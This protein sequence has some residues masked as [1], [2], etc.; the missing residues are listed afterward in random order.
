VGGWTRFAPAPTGYLHLGHVANAIWVWGLA[1]QTNRSVLLRIEDH[2]RERSRPEFDAA[3]LEDLA[4]LGFEPN[5]G[6]VRQRDM[7]G[8]Y[9]SALDRLRGD[10]LVYACHCSR[11]TFATWAAAHGRAFSGPGCP[12]G[13]RERTLADDGQTTLRVALGH[14]EEHWEDRLLGRRS[15]SVYAAGDLPIRDRQDN[16]TYGFAVVADDL[17]QGIDLVVRGEDL[18][19]ATPGQIRLGRLLG[20]RRP[21]Q[22]AHHTL[23]LKPNGAKLSKADNDTG[24]RDLREAGLKAEA[25]IG[26]AA[27]AVG[28]LE[29][30]RD[31]PAKDVATLVSAE[32]MKPERRPR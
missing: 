9:H 19:E 7:P 29:P 30:G 10:G 17:R 18:A 15:G 28:L 31:V 24:V 3:I 27:A 6:P 12:G 32:T 25:V 11:S 1:A 13:C 2:D 5:A 4:W 16:W 21:A 26:L 22:F 8:H 23:I 20:R 14:G